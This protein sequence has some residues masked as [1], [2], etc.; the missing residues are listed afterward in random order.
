MS[1]QKP[2][3]TD[4]DICCLIFLK[5]RRAREA[6]DMILKGLDH[7]PWSEPTLTL[8]LDY[9]S[10]MV[11]CLELM[12]KLLSGNWGSH[13]VCD[14]YKTI[15]NR[16]HSDPDFTALLKLSLT[17][18][19]YFFEPATDPSQSQTG[20]SIAEYI[21]EMERLFDELRQEMA[22]KHP[23]Y[24]VHKELLL[25]RSVGEYLRDNVARFYQGEQVLGRPNAEQVRAISDDFMKKLE[26][27]ARMIDEYI[28]QANGVRVAEFQTYHIAALK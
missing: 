2:R 10:N 25:P 6:M 19:K 15:F 28:K 4:D 13:D 3:G 11:S 9:I 12:A 18:Q 14:M 17:N 26:T 16:A 27:V 8:L 22:Q 1:K 20:K 24:F 23:R 21:P 7:C 5:R